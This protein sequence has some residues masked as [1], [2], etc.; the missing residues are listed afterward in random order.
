V[1]RVRR[2]K[3]ARARSLNLAKEAVIGAEVQRQTSRTAAGRAHGEE[4]SRPR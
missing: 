4:H 2:R 3:V 1:R